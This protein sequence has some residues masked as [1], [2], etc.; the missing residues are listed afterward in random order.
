M[1]T[2][3]NDENDDF[4]ARGAGADSWFVYQ[5]I[6]SLKTQLANSNEARAAAESS[7]QLTVSLDVLGAAAWISL[8]P[9]L[10][11]CTAGGAAALAPPQRRVD[12]QHAASRHRQ[13]QG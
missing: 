7:C 5:V 13:N 8:T 1:L 3:K 9:C 4:S 10:H 6:A 12:G 11:A 2:L